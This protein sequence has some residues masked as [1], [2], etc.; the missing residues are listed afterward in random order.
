VAAL[1]EAD[2]ER[3]FGKPLSLLWIDAIMTAASYDKSGDDNDA[4]E[5]QKVMNALSAIVRQTGAFVIGID[6]FGKVIGTGTRGSSAKEGAV[7]TVLAALGSR[8]VNG[9][10]TETRLALR[11][12][13]DGISGI[14]LP[15]VAEVIETGR[16]EDGDPI[17]AV[18]LNWNAPPVA[19]SDKWPKSL[20]LFH[21][22]LVNALNV[23]GQ[24]IGDAGRTVRGTGRRRPRRILSSTHFGRH[25]RAAQGGPA[26][27]IRPR[28]EGS[29]EVRD[30]A[31]CGEINGMQWI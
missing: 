20:K 28:L 23:S 26:E 4:A 12:Q 9:T 27:S 19:T 1:R 29:T 3:R 13:R 25:R 2:I 24:D 15:F 21:R 6:H 8:D 7:D 5:T 11:K 10:V 30:L 17:T 18:E 22:T 31:G 16:D 14:E